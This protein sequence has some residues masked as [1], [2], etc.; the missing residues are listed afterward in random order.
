MCAFIQKSLLVRV[1]EI[2]SM[3]GRKSVRT[4]Y[5][6]YESDTYYP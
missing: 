1:S 4:Q 3:S 2:D 6:R 5:T